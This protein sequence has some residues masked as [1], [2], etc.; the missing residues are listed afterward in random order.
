MA[1]VPRS[2]P[3]A[4][5]GRGNRESRLL[6]QNRPSDLAVSDSSFPNLHL[7][8]S[9]FC[10]LLFSCH[11]IFLLLN[12]D[13]DLRIWLSVQNYSFQRCWLLF[14][15]KCGTQYLARPL[16]RDLIPTFCSPTF[17]IRC[18]PKHLVEARCLDWGHIFPLKQ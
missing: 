6:P 8:H 14:P 17:K 11:F 5:G 3:R 9:S 18:W 10:L 2:Q 12:P 15:A 16:H 1:A 13:L 4:V 7:C